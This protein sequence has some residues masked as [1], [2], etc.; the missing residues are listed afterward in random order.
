MDTT[1]M[2]SAKM[3][4][5]HLLK[6]KTFLNKGYG[7]IIFIHD[8]TSKILSRDSNYTVDDVMWPKFGNSSISIREVITS[9]LWGFDQ[10]NHFFKGYEQINSYMAN[11]EKIII[12]NTSCSIAI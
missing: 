3:A 6:I 12:T 2:M 7:I 11:S 10:K 1:L 9:I 8:V 5:L 4:T